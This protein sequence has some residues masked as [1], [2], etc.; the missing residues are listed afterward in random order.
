MPG[1]RLERQD[2]AAVMNMRS[3]DL[4]TH[5]PS[6]KRASERK[7][8]DMWGRKYVVGWSRVWSAW[9][10]KVWREGGRRVKGEAEGGKEG[11][12]GDG[13]M[14]VESKK[15]MQPMTVIYG[16]DSRAGFTK[17]EWSWG[18]DDGCVRGGHLVALVIGGE[19]RNGHVRRE[20]VRVKCK[21]Y[22]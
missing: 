3:I 2:P 17:R 7:G 4:R 1:V 12:D 20:A 16:H 15:M 8:R 14:D 11:V 6:R 9:Q 19:K 22:V 13:G 5:L 10:E 21:K 18:L